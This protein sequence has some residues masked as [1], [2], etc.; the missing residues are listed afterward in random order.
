MKILKKI[1]KNNEALV[2]LV[3][4]VIIGML[5]NPRFL[6]IENTSNVLRSASIQGFIA[7]GMTFVILCGSIDLSVANMFGL[8]GYLF[9]V[10]SSKSALLAILV[11]LVVCTLIGLVN[12]CI[13]GV[14]RIPSFVGTLATSL[15]VNGL[16][17]ILTKETTVTPAAP[18]SG[19]LK[20]LGRGSVL[21]A[22][23]VPLILFVVA[24]IVAAYILKMT[25]FGRSMYALG[26]NREAATMMGIRTERA[27][28]YTHIV[29]GLCSGIAGVLFASRVGSAHPQAGTGYELYAIASAVIG[30]AKLSGGEGKM[31]GTFI[32]VLVMSSFNNIFNMQQVINAVWE[33]TVV[34]VVLLL[35]VLAQAIVANKGNKTASA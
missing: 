24:T 34:G 7:I 1:L 29:C 17:L 32:G 14:L 22:V 30:G 2:G 25:P 5:V 6:S 13:V 23:P 21:G 9:I 10:F 31:T 12:G 11:P 20:M 27:M 35:V 19:F 26:G 28:I 4:V 33:Y 3:M 16:V 8:A 15:L 18:L